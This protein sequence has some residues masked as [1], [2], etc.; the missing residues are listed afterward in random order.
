MTVDARFP[1]L[2]AAAW[3]IGAAAAIAQ[4]LFARELMVACL[5]NELTIGL[6]LAVWLAG[7]GIGAAV[8]RRV[9]AGETSGLRR[10]AGA[11]MAAGGAVLP[12]QLLS[13]RV[14]RGVVGVPVG[15][16]GSLGHVLAAASIVCLPTAFVVGM[17]FPL[18]CSAAAADS[19]ADPSVE[20]GRLYGWESLGSMAAGVLLT[21][22]LLPHRSGTAIAAIGGGIA[23]LGASF[24]LGRM[25]RAVASAAGAVLLLAGA[26]GAPLDGVD[27]FSVASRWR[28]AGLLGGGARLADSRDTVYQN[29]ALV[30]RQGQF[31][32]YA[33]GSIAVTFPDRLTSEHEIHA[34]M[35]QR[36]SA[37]KV[38]LIGGNPLDDVRE[39]LRYP[40]DRLVH[41]DIDPGVGRIV[42]DAAPA[43]WTA[44]AGDARLARVNEDALRYLKRT[45][46]SFDLVIV[47]A[48]DPSTLAANRYF[49][50]EFFA[51]VGRRLEPAGFVATSIGLSERLQEES[52]TLGASVLRALDSVFPVVL[53]S[54][55]ARPLMLGGSLDSDLTLDRATLAA[56]SRA[57]A[58]GT[59]FFRPEYFFGTDD[60]DPEKIAAAE[61]R[62]RGASSPAN[63]MA[64]PVA[65]AQS[66]AM[67]RRFSGT[68]SWVAAWVAV[69]AAVASVFWAG[70]RLV[71]AAGKGAGAASSWLVCCVVATTGMAAI[72]IE[73]LS[74]LVYQSTCGYVYTRMGMVFAMF[75]LGLAL[76]ARSGR[77][78][79]G[80]RGGAWRALMLLECGMAA[81]AGATMLLVSLSG[82]A[83]E[84]TSVEIAV[85]ACVVLTG[86]VTG[87]E[88]PVAVRILTGGGGSAGAVVAAADTADHA[89]A[90]VGAMATA[91]V[92]VP[93][94]GAMQAALVL[95]ALKAAMAV[96]CAVARNRGSGQE[97]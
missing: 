70:T 21:L 60:Y 42:G 16:V 93:Y 49:T 79:T 44:A 90:A 97:R 20:S 48:A 74:I 56:R 41:V 5:G 39:L 15:E 55:G 75:M 17:A 80:G 81:L 92:L 63:T 46:D 43:E 38:L 57:A 96:S 27:A 12:L 68:G 88:F 94:A 54:A 61:A 36:P 95:L 6:V 58:I 9:R 19:E 33:N 53:V 13:A 25:A 50:A 89:G 34:I 51:D 8:A 62:L 32:L 1:R 73:L 45:R 35:A 66:L 76:G 22:L 7:I 24:V 67:W 10:A 78:W 2:R 11:L 64:R 82:T 84:G 4:V 26:A 30:E 3:C 37:R 47:R 85:Y 71:P 28:V 91:V 77:R 59:R 31:T 14:I 83:G 52:A 72:S 23:I 86:W 87:A 69:L 18:L 29:L 65:T 40:L